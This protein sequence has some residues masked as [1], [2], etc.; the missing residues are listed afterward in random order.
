MWTGECGG[1]KTSEES[2]HTTD[3]DT[4]NIMRDTLILSDIR[5]Y[6]C[7]NFT[8]PE[9]CFISPTIGPGPGCP[10]QPWSHSTT[11]SVSVS[12]RYVIF[13]LIKGVN[14]AKQI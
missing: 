8:T 11:G 10:G 1:W 9:V 3:T 2:E 14:Q 4:L 13:P 6:R 12:S 5:Y 7:Y